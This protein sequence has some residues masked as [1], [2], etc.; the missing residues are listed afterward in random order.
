MANCAV[1]L[2][3]DGRVRIGLL[4][5]LM[6]LCHSQSMLHGQQSSPGQAT[7]QGRKPDVTT[8]PVTD[9]SKQP[10][11]FTFEDRLRFYK[12]TTFSPFAFAGP[13]A[14]AAVSQWTTGNPPEWGQGFAGYGKRLLSGY[15]RDWKTTHVGRGL[16]GDRLFRRAGSSCRLWLARIHTRP[17]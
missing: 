11:R 14:G 17:A 12:Q 7:D 4:V 6:F 9:K 10:V 8:A 15:S 16:G 13:I 3:F 2:G 1:K 5:G